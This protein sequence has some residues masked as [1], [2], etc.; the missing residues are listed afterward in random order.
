MGSEQKR[1]KEEQDIRREN[2]EKRKAS[3]R[4]E[5][6]DIIREKEERKN[7]EARTRK[8]IRIGRENLEKRR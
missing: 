2:L 1:G 3:R 7:E 5:W 6:K 4:E 8:K